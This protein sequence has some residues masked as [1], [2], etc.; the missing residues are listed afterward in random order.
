MKIS[1]HFRPSDIKI[2]IIRREGPP[3]LLSSAHSEV[4]IFLISLSPLLPLTLSYFKRICTK[5]RSRHCLRTFKTGILH[6]PKC[7]VSHGSPASISLCCIQQRSSESLEAPSDCTRRRRPP[8]SK[9]CWEY[10][11]QTSL[12]Q[13]AGGVPPALNVGVRF[14]PIVVRTNS[15]TGFLLQRILWHGLGKGKQL[16]LR[17]LHRVSSLKVTDHLGEFG[18]GGRVI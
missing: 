1:L 15:A 16:T 10:I 2:L 6:S 3:Q 7:R 13:P 8:N 18:T 11:E 12:G 17:I 9:C 5:R 4:P 14:Q